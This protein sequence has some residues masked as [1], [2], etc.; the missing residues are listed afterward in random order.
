[1]NSVNIWH[2]LIQTLNIGYTVL[3]C[4]DFP[5]VWGWDS[6]GLQAEVRTGEV[7]N[8]TGVTTVIMRYCDQPASRVGSSASIYIHS[9]QRYS[10]LDSRPGTTG[11]TL[12]ACINGP[13][14]IYRDSIFQGNKV[15][16]CPLLHWTRA[17]HVVF[18]WVCNSSKEACESIDQREE[19]HW[20][21]VSRGSLPQF[22]TP[23]L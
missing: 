23:P 7:Q 8:S 3:R 4:S 15:C 19:K 17:V 18:L 11:S 1:M 20:Y 22:R 5:Y 13:Y 21:P 2:T 12:L 6:T 9:R 14:P 10:E 16:R